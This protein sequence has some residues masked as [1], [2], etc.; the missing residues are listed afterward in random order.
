[1]SSL[2]QEAKSIVFIP[3]KVFEFEGLN[4]IF[5]DLF[6]LSCAGLKCAGFFFFA[7]K[8]HSGKEKEKKERKKMY[9]ENASTLQFMSQ[10][11]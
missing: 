6:I 3:C 5:I 7:A 1:M 8:A 4:A 10:S 11:G 2:S 9:G